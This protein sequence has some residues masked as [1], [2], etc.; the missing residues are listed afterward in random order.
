MENMAGGADRELEKRFRA[1]V[2]FFAIVTIAAAGLTIFAW[3]FPT[4]APEGKQSDLTPVWILII[5]IAA[6]SFVLRRVL[7]RW[8]RFRDRKL[9]GGSSG[10]LRSLQANAFILGGIGGL[11][12]LLGFI[13]ARASGDRFDMLRAGVAA[14]IVLAINFPRRSIW[15]KVA[16]S[17]D[18]I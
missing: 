2:L 8:E 12:A 13:A 7:F 4:S 10:L 14:L 17:L 15:L 6:G 11:I 5:F 1:A 9:L 16:K 3:L 18:E